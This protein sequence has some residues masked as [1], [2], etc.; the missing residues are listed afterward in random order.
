MTTFAM[1]QP[2]K[3]L[4]LTPENIA[5][6]IYEN[7]QG[8]VGHDGYIMM[9][10]NPE[11]TKFYCTL[12]EPKPSPTPFAATKAEAIR[13]INPFATTEAEAI[14]LIN[15]FA[16]TEAEAR[17]RLS[18]IDKTQGPQYCDNGTN[19][20]LLD[21][22]FQTETVVSQAP[23]PEPRKEQ[24]NEKEAKQIL[25]DLG[26]GLV[27]PFLYGVV[28]ASVSPPPAYEA[29]FQSSSQPIQGTMAGL[30]ISTANNKRKRI[31]DPRPL[32]AGSCLPSPCRL[33]FPT[34]LS[35][36]TGRP[37]Y[38]QGGLEIRDGNVN[39]D[40]SDKN[41]DNPNGNP[42][43]N[44]ND[45]SNDNPDDKSSDNDKNDADDD[46]DA[47]DEDDDDVPRPYPKRR[48]IRATTEDTAHTTATSAPL[49]KKRKNPVP[50]RRTVIPTPRPPPRSR[51][52]GKGTL[53]SIISY[54][55]AAEITG[56][57]NE[58]ESTTAPTI[59]EEAEVLQDDRT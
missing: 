55:E 9:C 52:S 57:V 51:K 1:E 26:W 30:E 35:T 44:S 5:C 4:W 10:D 27:A 19:T 3:G 17:D 23:A 37:R 54:N 46:G 53:T 39:S 14:R 16:M 21:S 12:K 41:S 31:A 11:G 43:G 47:D 25:Q 6:E 40:N 58:A 7:I 22:G 28:T 36:P 18:E 42:I 8:D 13:L 33:P 50:K 34:S 15:P 29:L 2:S 32:S 48:K 20:T 38:I 49:Q 45:T 59:R 56:T 24:L